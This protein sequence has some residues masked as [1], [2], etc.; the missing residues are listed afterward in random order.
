VTRFILT[1]AGEARP[2]TQAEDLAFRRERS[3]REEFGHAAA[4]RP[5]RPASHREREC[6][7][8]FDRLTE[9]LRALVGWQQLSKLAEWIDD[10]YRRISEAPIES[11]CVGTSAGRQRESATPLPVAAPPLDSAALG[12]A[13]TRCGGKDGPAHPSV[14]RA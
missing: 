9:E 4:R 2:L 11:S 3:W 8:T 14:D 13:E 1:T 10:N 12:T 7:H 6:R 5:G